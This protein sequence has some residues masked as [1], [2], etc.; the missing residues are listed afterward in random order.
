MSI[1]HYLSKPRISWV[2]L[3]LYRAVMALVIVVSLLSLLGCYKTKSYRG[4]G[5]MVGIR[6]GSWLFHCTYYKVTL[7][8]VDFTK[9]S[10]NTFTLQG[11]PHE[12]MCLGFRTK[13]LDPL[14]T[15]ESSQSDALVKVILVDEAG[16][17][18]IHEQERLNRWTWS[19][20]GEET[21]VYRRG[22]YGKDGQ[23]ILRAND[24]GWGTYFRPR[25]KIKYTLTVEIIEPKSKGKYQN[26]ELEMA[27]LC[28]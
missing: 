1:C 20:G 5:K 18:V 16:Q 17:L 7:G 6:V 2:H 11:L 9:K 8:S 28:F 24:E 12:M 3:K 23:E 27:N 10:M 14:P 22:H 15:F 26:A 13:L 21:F 4:D 19:Y 25:T